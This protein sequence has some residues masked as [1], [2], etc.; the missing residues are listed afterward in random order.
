MYIADLVYPACLVHLL[1]LA[2]MVYAVYIYIYIVHVV[3]GLGFQDSAAPA[4]QH[5][6]ERQREVFSAQL[7]DVY[8][9]LS[10]LWSR[11]GP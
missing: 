7:K 1:Y 5:L 2:Y 6:T 4:L 10:K 3:S 9:W 11:L 8:G